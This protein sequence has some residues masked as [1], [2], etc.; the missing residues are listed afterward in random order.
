[1]EWI[2]L[3]KDRDRWVALVNAVMK[4]R[5]SQNARNFLTSRGPKSFSRTTVLQTCLVQLR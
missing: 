1:M 2:E 4:L 3:A 5:I